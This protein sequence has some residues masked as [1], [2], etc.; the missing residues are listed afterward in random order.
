MGQDEERKVVRFCIRQVRCASRHY[1]STLSQPS[2]N[3]TTTV[4]ILDIDSTSLLEVAFM[5]SIFFSFSLLDIARGYEQ[6]L[7]TKFD[8]TESITRCPTRSVRSFPNSSSSPR[9]S[10]PGTS[11]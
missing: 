7:L 4:S 6:D 3:S 9:R 8:I 2:A 5:V 11:K 1:I 10:S